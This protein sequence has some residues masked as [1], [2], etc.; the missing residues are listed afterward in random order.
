[1]GSVVSA[2][3]SIF[4]GPEK[5]AVP[6][7]AAAAEKTQQANMDMARYATRVNRPTQITPYGTQTW[8]NSGGFDQAGYDA[9]MQAYKDSYQP[10]TGR[11]GY[12]KTTGN[13]GDQGWDREWVST[14]NEGRYTMPK[15]NRDDFMRED[16]W[17]MTTTLPDDLQAAL[18]NDFAMRKGRSQIGLDMMDQAKEAI[19]TPVDYDSAQQWSS[20]P[21]VS[22]F[23]EYNNNVDLQ[24]APDVSNFQAYNNPLNLQNMGN[25]PELQTQ[26]RT[27]NLQNVNALTNSDISNTP[28]FDQQY[29][30]DIK[31]QTLDYMRPEM[32]AKQEALDAQLAAQGI[33]PGSEAYDRAQRRL[34]DQQSRD[35]YNALR[36]G[37]DQANAMYRNQLAGNDQQ[38]GQRQG[39]FNSELAANQNQF[40][41]NA[42]A[43]QFTNAALGAQNQMGLAN[44]GFN[45]QNALAQDQA[46]YRNSQQYNAIQSDLY[47]QRYQNTGFNN[48][49]QLTANDLARQDNSYANQLRQQEFGQQQ[50][51]ANY[52]NQLRQ[53]QIAEAIQRQQVPLNNINALISGQQVAMPNM[54]AF[55]Q[56]QRAQAG[57]Y[58]NAGQMQYNADLQAQQMN[59]ASA[60]SWMNGAF[61]L[62]GKLGGAYLGN[63]SAFGFGGQ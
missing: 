37:M 61:S 47:N 24:N 9:A 35:E 1:M 53:A 23:Q 12:W 49:N 3:G 36:L 32:Q 41:Q 21:Q 20:A 58:L 51:I 59:N 39:V 45:N 22:D 31:N 52:Q 48:Q 63:P 28:T 10:G 30:N 40:G 5:P 62:G 8:T 18:D 4:S 46:G 57:Q 33:T 17:T 26:L 7:Y 60:N 11:G 43:G 19:T 15:P 34:A 16:D 14:G 25:A 56:A 55:N 29:V 42:T 44:L 27:D 6:D 50:Q 54:P 13:G 38:F 2:V